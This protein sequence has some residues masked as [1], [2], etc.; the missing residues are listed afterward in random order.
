M[1][2]P[3]KPIRNSSPLSW[4]ALIFAVAVFILLMLQK[5]DSKQLPA[6]GFIADKIDTYK[7]NLGEDR[8]KQETGGKG[9]NSNS[10]Y[11]KS[12][13][14]RLTKALGIKESDILAITD[15]N[16]KLQDTVKLVRVERD[17]ANNKLWNW[18]KTYA[19][20]SKVKATMS[21][22]DSILHT[23]IDVKLQ[24]TDYVEKGGLFKKTK[25]YTDI[26]SPD[27]NISINGLKTYRKETV[28]KPKRVGIGVQFGY[29]LSSDFK[30]APYV[31]IGLSYN[32]LSF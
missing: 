22:K 9:D 20:G 5:C 30:I 26:Y 27:Q 2:N 24:V 6:G 31:G 3:N 15:V 29:G 28:I 14:A 16:A 18:E 21:E 32:V 10:A 23:D 13:I 7:D 17:A 1:E 8:A 11:Y 19:S 25:Y 12:E 4:L